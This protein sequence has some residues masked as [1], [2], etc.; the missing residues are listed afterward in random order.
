[1]TEQDLEREGMCTLE[2]LV[3]Y[4]Q[5]TGVSAAHAAHCATYCTPCRPLIRAFS[6]WIRTPPCALYSPRAA[7][8]LLLLLLYSRTGPRRA[9]SLKL[10]DTRVYEPKKRTRL[11]RKREVRYRITI[12]VRGTTEELLDTHTSCSTS[13]R[14]DFWARFI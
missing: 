8:G 11:G 2:R 14:S 12:Y 13:F 9:L 4:C 5:T 3:I 10:S 7:T 1:M 6:G